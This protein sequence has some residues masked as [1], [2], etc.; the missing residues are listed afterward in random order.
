[1]L[2][3]SVHALGCRWMFAKRLT[4]LRGIP[5][6]SALRQNTGASSQGCCEL[7]VNADG[8]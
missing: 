4:L 7:G 5:P 8:H 2:V 3:D 1:M 6:Q